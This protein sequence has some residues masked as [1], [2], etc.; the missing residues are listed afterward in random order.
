MSIIIM[1]LYFIL[2][3]ETMNFF[4]EGN[5]LYNSQDYLR[6]IDCYKRA[7]SKKENELAPTIMLVFASLNLKIMTMLLP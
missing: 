3:E 6:A 1:N 4:S 2:M 7:V 5:K